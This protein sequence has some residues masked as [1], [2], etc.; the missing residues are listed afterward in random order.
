MAS[1]NPNVLQLYGLKI[2]LPVSVSPI[3]I[4]PYSTLVL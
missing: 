3:K 4:H 1:A 2:D